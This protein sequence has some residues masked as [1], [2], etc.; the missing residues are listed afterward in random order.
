[1]TRSSAG[2]RPPGQQV[3]LR[4]ARVLDN[5]EMGS[6]VTNASVDDLE[7]FL[8]M[9]ELQLEETPHWIKDEDSLHKSL[10]WTRRVRTMVTEVLHNKSVVV[11]KRAQILGVSGKVF[12]VIVS[13]TL[14]WFLKEYF[15]K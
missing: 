4:A 6:L 15:S 13:A 2:S 9:L 14:G 1:M 8:Q 5:K 11:R 7:W 3:L 12:L 10:A